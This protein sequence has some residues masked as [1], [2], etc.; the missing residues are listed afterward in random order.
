MG[1]TS[2][3]QADCKTL[4]RELSNYIDER[5]ERKLQDMIE[6]HLAQCGECT[7]LIKTMR[8][9][10]EMLGDRKSFLRAIEKH[11]K[12]PNR[13]APLGNKGAPDDS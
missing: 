11:G 6:A 7:A 12:T 3:S 9:M 8:Q 2:Q 4:V 1:R 13:A 5:L 10:L